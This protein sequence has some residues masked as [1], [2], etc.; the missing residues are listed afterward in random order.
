MPAWLALCQAAD[1]IGAQGLGRHTA[2]AHALVRESIPTVDRD[3]PMDLEIQAV[4]EMIR[5]GALRAAV[6]GEQ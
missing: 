4:A 1:I 2:R 6:T 5:T 3:R